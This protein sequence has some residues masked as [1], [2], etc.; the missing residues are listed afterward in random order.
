MCFYEKL[1]FVHLG[2]FKKRCIF[3]K[4][5]LYRMKIS[6]LFFAG[7][8]FFGFLSLTSAAELGE[9]TPELEKPMLDAMT[10]GSEDK[11]LEKSDREKAL[12]TLTDEEQWLRQYF[13]MS[14][15][16]MAFFLGVFDGFNPCAMWSLMMLLGFL[17][18]MEDKRR[19]WIIGGVFLASSG[20]IY[21]AA[22]L[23]YLFG[24]HQ[25]RSWL[26]GVQMDW[27]FFGVGILAIF[28][29]FGSFYAFYQNKVECKIRDADEKRK[30]HQ[31]LSDLLKK[32]DLFLILPGLIV[33]A[34]SVNS[35]ELL[36]SLAIPTAFTATL[37]ERELPL[38][39]QLL[40][41]L[42]YDIFYMIDDIVVFG[43]A[44]FTFKITAFS[45]KMVRWSHLLGG[46]VLLL[47]GSLLVFD[48]GLLTDIF[49]KIGDFLGGFF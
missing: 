10:E 27:I 29:A 36:C 31:K 13:D 41:I 12:D 15:P 30:F 22:L 44:M 23:A 17:L 42:I 47:I 4:D 11:T 25:I 45:T 7:A 1:F 35:V 33:L 49:R 39:S 14:W 8:L 9:G 19:R 6:H 24:F 34:F 5:F 16:M 37:V 40:A 20:I 26:T 48:I 18:T 3:Q 28:S 43:I 32:E 2:L 38:V 21:G 46:A